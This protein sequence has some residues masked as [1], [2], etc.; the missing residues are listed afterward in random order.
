MKLMNMP[1]TLLL[2]LALVWASMGLRAQNTL[3]LGMAVKQAMEHN[4]GIL[5]AQNNSEIA[6]NN[7]RAGNAGLLPKVDATGA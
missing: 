6:Q 1:K 7:A 3:T 2:G 5:V 4:H